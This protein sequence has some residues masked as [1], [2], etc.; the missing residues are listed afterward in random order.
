MG[1]KSKEMSEDKEE[2]VKSL[3][4]ADNPF[5]RKRQP[6]AVD[7]DAGDIIRPAKKLGSGMDSSVAEKETMKEAKIL[8]SEHSNA[9]KR[10]RETGI[11]AAV[12]S[13]P[14][15]DEESIVRKRMKL[16]EDAE[17]DGSNKKNK[18]RK[19][20]EVEFEYEKKKLGSA[21]E[22]KPA[23]TVVAVGEKRKADMLDTK[24]SFDDE[25]KLLRTV[26]IGNLPL[27][28]KIKA[29]KREFA[30]FGEIESVR[31]RSVP[32]VDTKAPR[33]AAVIKGQI[34]EEVDSM[35]AYIVFKEEQSAHAA[36]SN[37][38]TQI[39]ENHIRVD[40]AC[41]PR[42]KMKG[43]ARLYDRKRTAFVGNLPFDV[44][45]EE[46]YQLFCGLSQSEPNVE[47]VRVIRDPNTSIG[48]GIAYV[49]F[50]TRDA[51]NNVCKRRDLKIRDRNLRVCHAKSDALPSKVKEGP[52]KRFPHQ[53]QPTA[54]SG[55]PSGRGE[56]RKRIDTDSVS[57]EGTRSSKTGVLK[58]SSFRPPQSRVSD[59]GARRSSWNE[60][61]GRK[62]KR[63]AVAARKAKEHQKRKQ[64][65]GAS[66][67][68][69]R[70]K[71]ARR[72]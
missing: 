4:G 2:A 36:L 6:D 58:K 16:V 71:R 20:D 12:P 50:K 15:S 33:K 49:L 19:R 66:E 29:L 7:G 67:N 14:S 55:V 28:T 56:K 11:I 9:R 43:D 35:N 53:R 17:V 8:D 38:M 18:K 42:K 31:I 48:K 59:S 61:Q 34:N 69:G 1:K 70:N 54:H 5:R 22:D 37:N 68:A 27:K 30:R 44:K 13:P 23:A 40:M 10:K 64:P 45:D 65:S 25:S 63:P 41:P 26:F 46:L 24:E 51:A 47:A 21:G 32:L 3:F 62:T 39:G 60:Q 52:S 57:Y 72:Q